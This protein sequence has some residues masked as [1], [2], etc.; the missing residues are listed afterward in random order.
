MKISL[1]KKAFNLD[2]KNVIKELKDNF[3]WAINKEQIEASINFIL[4]QRGHKFGA[5]LL[6]V[7]NAE[8]TK[9][10]FS[11]T[12]WIKAYAIND[13][14]GKVF[15]IKFDLVQAIMEDENVDALIYIYQKENN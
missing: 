10:R 4:N 3:S 12:Y 2:E 7:E 6:T 8:I 5:R 13:L 9:N 11:P 1:D 14:F 15:E